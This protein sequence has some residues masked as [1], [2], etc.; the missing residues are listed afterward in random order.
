MTTQQRSISQVWNVVPQRGRGPH[1]QVAQV[2]APVRWSDFDPFLIMMEDWFGQGTFD[3]H[4]HRGMETVTYVIEGKLKHEDNHGGLGIL[5]PGDVQWMTAGRGVIHSEDPLPGET[6]HSLQL[7]VN[8]PRAHKMTQPRYQDLKAAQ[9]PVRREPGVEIRVFSGSSGDV[10]ADT[11]NHVP[12]T[13]LDLKLEPG[14][15]VEQAVPASYR[16]FFYILEGEGTFGANNTPG[17]KNQV[18]WV[19]ALEAGDG[20]ASV[21]TVEAK[22]A[23]HALWIAG[24]PLHEPIAAHGPFVMNTAEEIQQAFV[25]YHSGNFAN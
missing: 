4:P 10:K 7:W 9:M 8:L 12:V 25:D 20:T 19:N 17:E 6:V 1:L 3:F 18:L 5:E 24:K 16:G 22:T 21:V 14:A 11:L 2:L 23:L 13:Y 15:K